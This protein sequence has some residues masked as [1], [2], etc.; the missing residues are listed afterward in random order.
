MRVVKRGEIVKV[1]RKIKLCI[2]VLI[3][4]LIYMT[5]VYANSCEP[6]SIIVIVKNP[7]KDLSIDTYINGEYIKGIKYK[8]GWEAYFA[9]YTVYS[10][11]KSPPKFFVRYG[12]IEFDYVHDSNMYGH[13]NIFTLDIEN[14]K[15]ISGVYPYRRLLI[16]L[17]RLL[18][19]LL[20][21]S[22]VFYLFGFRERFSWVV[23]T[24][25]NIITQLGLN[26][27]LFDGVTRYFDPYYISFQ[28]VHIELYVLVFELIVFRLL[29][30]EKSRRRINVYTILSNIISL[31]LGG[32]LIMYLPI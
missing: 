17:P 13:R 26:W 23:F 14:E 27:K 15:L 28:L 4:A 19:T 25:T 20:I 24:I 30:K 3:F 32:Y 1:N 2:M 16:I 29:I 12:D 21:E 9:Y 5:I 11:K 22:I 31:V 10:E 7:P 18:L 6:P 8:A